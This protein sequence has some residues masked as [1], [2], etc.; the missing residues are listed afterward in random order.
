MPSAEL[1][2]AW[3]KN[4]YPGKASFHLRGNHRVT[5]DGETA[6]VISTGYAWNKVEGLEAGDLWEVW[7]N[8]EH[9]FERRGGDWKVTSFEFAP[10]H[11]RGNLDIPTYQ[12]GQ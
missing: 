3:E 4:L 9:G 7:G 12:P 10:V 8:Y 11:Q 6:T 2:S 1:V 5:V